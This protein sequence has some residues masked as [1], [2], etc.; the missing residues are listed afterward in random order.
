MSAFNTFWDLTEKE[1]AAL[2]EPDVER[3][4]D[5]ELMTK[6]VLK[7]PPFTL[8]RVE[9]VALATR[10]VFGISTD[11]YNR[12]DVAFETAERAAEF[13]KLQPLHLRSEYL[14]GRSVEYIEPM[15]PGAQIAPR[16]IATHEAIL[17][18]KVALKKA[19]AAK[20]ENERR[21]RE[22]EKAVKAQE[23]VLQGLWDEWHR[24]RELD[25]RRRRT[26]E[27]FEDYKRIAGGDGQ[28]AARFLLKVFSRE[29]IAEAAEWCGVEIPLRFVEVDERP[30]PKPLVDNFSPG[31]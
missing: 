29:Q 21:Q 12:L 16:E 8:E 6:G 14:P 17:Q 2:S 20:E 18:S 26:L 4:I 25:T 19:A 27:T 13:L 3:F 22:Y 5:A 23:Q 31:F 30:A 11:H 1:R 15:P 24:C 9:E 7:V 10:T 28:V